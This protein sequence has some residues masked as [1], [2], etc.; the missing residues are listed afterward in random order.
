MLLQAL[1]DWPAQHNIHSDLSPIFTWRPRSP[2]LLLSQ[3]FIGNSVTFF[4]GWRRS[5][6]SPMDSYWRGQHTE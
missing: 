3:C 5:L 6:Q 2:R 1:T 4:E